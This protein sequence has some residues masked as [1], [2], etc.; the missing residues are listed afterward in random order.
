MIYEHVLL[1]ANAIICAVTSL[2]LI[3]FR[4]AMAAH[5]RLTSVIAYVL[6]V[7]TGS[8]TIRVITGE[9]F[10]TDWTEVLINLL[11]C[12]AVL[13]VRGN[14]GR[15]LRGHIHDDTRHTQ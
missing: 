14:V 2:R 1:N 7:A 6:V 8:V 13:R 3:T 5:N 15:L 10:Y 4:R 11:L 9:Y 12:I